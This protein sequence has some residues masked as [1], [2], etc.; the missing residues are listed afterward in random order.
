M[1]FTTYEADSAYQAPSPQLPL[2]ITDPTR[3]SREAPA[4][5][6]GM[7]HFTVPGRPKHATAPTGDGEGEK[8]T[9]RKRRRSRSAARDEL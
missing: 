7:A 3:A 5:G 6:L 9:A 4:K 8:T 2:G 1:N